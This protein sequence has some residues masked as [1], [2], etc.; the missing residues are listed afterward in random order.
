[1]GDTVWLAEGPEIAAGTSVTVIAI[2]GSRVV[3]EATEPTGH[4]PVGSR[5]A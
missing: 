5:V 2:R 1:L 4:L 3:V